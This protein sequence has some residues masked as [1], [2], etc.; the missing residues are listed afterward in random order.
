MDSTPTRPVLLD[1][2]QYPRCQ[3]QPGV[4]CGSRK[5]KTQNFYVKYSDV[6]MLAL[7]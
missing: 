2:S 5:A 4:S 1:P 6:E 7:N 3:A